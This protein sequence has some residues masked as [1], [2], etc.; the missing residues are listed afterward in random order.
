VQPELAKHLP[1]V[2]EKAGADE[3]PKLSFPVDNSR[4]KKDFEWDC[5]FSFPLPSLSAFS[6]RKT[7]FLSRTADQP[8]D[9]Y[10]RDFAKQI[11]Q[12]AKAGGQ[13]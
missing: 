2:P 8:F 12:L 4:V 6:V 7:A 10:V 5:A 9:E 13:L 1:P 11:Y 3:D